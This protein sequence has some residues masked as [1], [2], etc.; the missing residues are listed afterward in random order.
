MLCLYPTFQC[1]D[2]GFTYCTEVTL[3]SIFT[4]LTTILNDS[5]INAFVKLPLHRAT[6]RASKFTFSYC[7]RSINER[8][9][10]CPRTK[11]QNRYVHRLIV[12]PVS[13]TWKVHWMPHWKFYVN[14]LPCVSCYIES[15]NDFVCSCSDK[16]SIVP[17]SVP[18]FYIYM[19]YPKI[20]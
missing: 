4:R 1:F 2:T 16:R 13:S 9:C 10:G 18:S 19:L 15:A 14:V 7:E 8:F 12:T 20:L 11:C 3:A 5:V 6:L 17:A